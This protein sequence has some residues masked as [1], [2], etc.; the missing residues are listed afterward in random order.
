MHTFFEHP[1]WMIKVGINPPAI[2]RLKLMLKEKGFLIP[3]E[4]LE[5]NALV[6][7]VREQVML[8]E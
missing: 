7:C 8:H 6:K 5:L 2:I 1:E 4:I 3:D